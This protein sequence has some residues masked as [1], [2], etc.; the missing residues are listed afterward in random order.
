MLPGPRALPAL[1]AQTQT[2]RQSD[3]DADTDR[4]TD[5]KTK[6]QTD[7]HIQPCWRVRCCC[8]WCSALAAQCTE[9][10]HTAALPPPSSLA[11]SARAAVT[12][13]G[14]ALALARRI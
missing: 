2:D 13:L 11:P 12:E 1:D 4:R 5:R 14:Q 9:H 8:C 6:T 10:T 3:R 7:T